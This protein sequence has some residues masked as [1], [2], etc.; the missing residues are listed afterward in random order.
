MFTRIDLKWFKCFEDLVLPIA[1]LTLLSGTNASGKSTIFQSLV[2]LH[3]T[4]LRNEWATR[5]QLNGPELELGT[6]ADVI[7]KVHGR[8]RFRIGIA[9]NDCGIQWEFSSG[10]DRQEAMSVAVESVEVNGVPS[11]PNENLRFL[12]PESS[13]DAL[14]LTNRLRGMTYL[15]AE[16]TGPREVY[17][18]Q[19][20]D[21]TQVVGP[22]G[23]NAVGML[24]QRLDQEVLPLLLTEPLPP[25][26]LQQVGNRMR[27]FFPNSSIDV[28]HVKNTNFVTLGIK[29]SDATGFHRPM[30]VGFGLTQILPI[31]VAVLTA[32]EGDLLLIENPEVHLH[33]GGQAAMGRFLTHA[34]AAGVQVLV[35][36]HSDHVLNGIRRGVKAGEIASDA[37]ALHFFRSRDEDGPQVVS[38]QI[39]P[40]GNVDEW[41]EGFFDQFDKDIN[42]F[43]DW[44]E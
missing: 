13:N 35:E 20:P 23:D 19:D 10:E 11:G 16:R 42:H 30:H 1:P 15:T 37:V 8:G 18:L 32:S 31:I 39:D 5:L 25:K 44:G 17:Q 28:Q 29:T 3:Q 14:T 12:V 27:A 33:P 34:S 7:D 41:P 43:A 9:D 4:M 38:P 26:L 22:R 24:Y 21:S 2:L 6:A 36:T 40:S